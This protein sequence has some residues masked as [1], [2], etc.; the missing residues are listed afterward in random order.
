MTVVLLALSGLNLRGVAESADLW[1]TAYYP[2][3]R[4]GF[5]PATNIDFGAVSHVIHFSVVP[6]ADGT[7]DS[8]ANDLSSAA[9]AELITAAHGAGGKVL[10]CVG[11]ANSQGGFQGATSSNHLAS[12]IANIASFAATRGYDGVDIDWEPLESA[13]ASRFVSL[14]TGLRAVLDRTIPR[15]LLTTAVATEPALIAS[16]QSHFD[17]VNLMTYDL[18]GPYPGWV[19]WFNAPIFDGGYRFPSTHGLIPSADGMINSFLAA[20]VSPGKLSIGLAFYGTI[21]T[22]GTGTSTGGATLPRQG[23]A[24]APKVTTE[25]YDSIMSRDFR[26]EAYHWDTN[27]QSA[28]L[29]LDAPGSVD[30]RFISYDDEHAC[31]AKVSYAR[32]RGLGGVMIWEL[33]S[34]Y[35]PNQPS[36]LRDPLLQAVKQALVPP[37][38]AASIVEEAKVQLRFHGMPL[39]KYQIEWTDNLSTRD[40]TP[41]GGAISGVGEPVLAT[42]PTPVG[43]LPRYYRLR[44]PP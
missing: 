10:F 25:T 38:L 26:P 2:G 9:S 8:D 13:D 5:L 11:G 42:D 21:W 3:Y 41:L 1:T 15:P 17:Q 30:D 4:R 44:T 20:G 18:A 39:A 40:W 22:G 28:Y 33:G 32:N 31:Q 34:G 19:T 36:G 6:R 27:A 24:T 35:R 16:L 7:L 29:S 14:I 37:H 43:S 12:F 23:W